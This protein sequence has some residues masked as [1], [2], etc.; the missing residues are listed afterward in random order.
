MSDSDANRSIIVECPHCHTWVLPKADNTCPACQ[1]DLSDRE[2]VDPNLVVLMVHE[3]E[4][5]PSFCYSCNTY[6]ERFVRV[7]GDRN[8]FLKDAILGQVDPEDTSN[9]IIHLPQCE[10]CGNGGNPEPEDVDYER[11]TMSFVVHKRF[12]ERVIQAR[13][14]PTHNPSND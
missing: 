14:N 4:E 3:S 5:L 12:K 8:S 11:Q 2:G 6:T 9:V 1:S 7:S 13:E 10:D